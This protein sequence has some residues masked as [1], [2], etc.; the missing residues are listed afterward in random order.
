[1]RISRRAWLAAS[2]GVTLVAV[3]AWLL[4][5]RLHRASPHTAS[6]GASSSSTASTGQSASTADA[7]AQSTTLSHTTI[8][9]AASWI[10]DKAASRLTFKGLMDAAPF[11]GVFRSWAAKIAFDPKNLKGSKAVIT[12]DTESALTGQPIKDQALPNAEWL[13]ISRYPQAVLVTRAITE[14]S[15]GRYQAVADV[16]IRGFAHRTTVPFTVSITR[17]AGRMDATLTL[18]RRDFHI[19]EGPWQ[20]PP[21]VAPAFQVTMRLVA[22]RAR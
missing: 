5:P 7:T 9:P 11:D 19:G 20:S 1:M 15:P 21:P 3:I 17:D 8:S 18:D 6:D 14:V 22:K 4:W 13:N 12:V 16:K 2:A 10:V